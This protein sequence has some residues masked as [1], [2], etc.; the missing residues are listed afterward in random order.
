MAMLRES[1]GGGCK[2]RIRVR[3]MIRTSIQF[4]SI[5]FNSIPER[6]RGREER[7][8][9]SRAGRDGNLSSI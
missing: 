5:H 7:N 4:D 2:Y 3:V 8:H 6:E 9:V 1:T